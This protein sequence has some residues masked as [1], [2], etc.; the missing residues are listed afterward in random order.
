VFVEPPNPRVSAPITLAAGTHY[1]IQALHA[2]GGGGDFVKVGWRIST[3]TTSATNL[4]PIQA[5][6]LSAYASLPAPVFNPPTFSSGQVRISWT[7]VG[8]LYQSAD[9]KTWTPVPGNPASPYS[10]TPGPGPHLF[11]RIV[12]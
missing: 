1:F 9:L 6:Y 3:D 8:T 4:P 11:Y 12:Q 5:Q 10:V 7:G 2:E